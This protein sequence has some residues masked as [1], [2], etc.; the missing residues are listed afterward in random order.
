MWKYYKID[1]W[2]K[3]FCNF[4][5]YRK[6]STGNVNPYWAPYWNIS[7][8]SL[9]AK[10]LKLIYKR[11]GRKCTRRLYYDSSSFSNL[12]SGNYFSYAGRYRKYKIYTLTD[13]AIRYVETHY[14]EILDVSLSYWIIHRSSLRYLRTSNLDKMILKNRLPDVASAE[15]IIDLLVD[16]LKLW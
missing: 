9:N 11:L 12:L 3:E 2:P 4:H 14:D 13:R 10:F 8:T 1:N 7:P 15:D 16:E 6:W 5:L